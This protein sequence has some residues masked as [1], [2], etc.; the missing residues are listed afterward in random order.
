MI[1]VSTY[2]NR[3]GQ[4]NMPLGVKEQCMLLPGFLFTAMLGK[5]FVTD[6]LRAL[7]ESMGW[8]H[9]QEFE[10]AAMQAVVAAMLDGLKEPLDRETKILLVLH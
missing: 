6:S 1:G 10:I 7:F 9:G 2:R 8:K 5:S 3:H 4:F